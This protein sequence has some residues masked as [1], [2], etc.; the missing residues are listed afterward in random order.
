M[1][2]STPVAG[3]GQG[4]QGI[5]LVAF[6]TALATSLVI[7]GVQMLVFILL[8]DNLARILS[9][10]SMLIATKSLLI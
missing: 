1:A 6:I 3:S 5:S 2:T 10:S 7:F 4:S 8:K 9:V